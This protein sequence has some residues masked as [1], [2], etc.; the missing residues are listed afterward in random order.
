MPIHSVREILRVGIEDIVLTGGNTI[1]SLRGAYIPVIW[2][3]DVLGIPADTNERSDLA[4][5]VVETIGQTMGLVVGAFLQKLDTVVKPLG[6]L[7]SAAPFVSGATIL[8]DGRIVPV[9]DPSGILREASRFSERLR[10]PDLTGASSTGRFRSEAIGRRVL[11]VDDSL[12]M[13]KHLSGIL[14][15]AGYQVDTARDG[16]EGLRKARAGN[17]DLISTDIEM[18]VLDGYQLSIALR[19]DARFAEIPIIAVTG[20]DERVDR[21]EG[22]RAGFDEYLTKPVVPAGYLVTVGRLLAKVRQRSRS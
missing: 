9:L 4:L 3:A 5:V 16:G 22:F 6:N 11:V 20:K 21:L 14:T 13:L 10:I 8:G 15:G 17:Y 1:I 12:V 2:L 18:P 19:E 7:L